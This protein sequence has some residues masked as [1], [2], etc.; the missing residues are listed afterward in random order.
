MKDGTIDIELKDG[1]KQSLPFGTCIWA[2]GVG[3]HPLVRFWVGCSIC[4]GCSLHP[5]LLLLHA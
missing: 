4:R 2:A 1:T 3:M 5:A